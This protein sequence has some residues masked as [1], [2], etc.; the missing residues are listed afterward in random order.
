MQVIKNV[1]TPRPQEPSSP[2]EFAKFAGWLADCAERASQQM[3]LRFSAPAS[4]VE[5]RRLRG[6]I[7]VA[8]QRD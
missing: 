7:W 8:T 1:E 6:S 5:L 2:R 4:D 3:V